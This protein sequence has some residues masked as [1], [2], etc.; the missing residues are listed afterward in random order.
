MACVHANPDNCTNQAQFINS[1]TGRLYCKQHSKE[2]YDTLNQI[3]HMPFIL[4]NLNTYEELLPKPNTINEHMNDNRLT[5]LIKMLAGPIPLILTIWNELFW[6]ETRKAQIAIDEAN[7]FQLLLR[8]HC[9]E[10]AKKD[11][12]AI[13]WGNGLRLKIVSEEELLFSKWIQNRTKYHDSIK[14]LIQQEEY[15]ANVLCENELL[16]LRNI[17]LMLYAQYRKNLVKRELKKRF[18]ISTTE[19]ITRTMVFCLMVHK[20]KQYLKNYVSK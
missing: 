12:S 13:Y 1:K 8:N 15:E 14:N 19:D 9:N 4:E 7:E 6:F 5:R 11:T 2:E 10:L 17:K 3:V 20:T 16:E 18:A